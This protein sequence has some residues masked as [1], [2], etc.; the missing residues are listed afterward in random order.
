LRCIRTVELYCNAS[1]QRVNHEKSSIYFGKEVAG[2]TR[3]E[4]KVILNMENESLS[5]R[6]LGLP[7]DVGRSKN[8]TFAYLKDRVWKRL[9]GWMERL[10]S[11]GGKEI[12]RKSVIQV[13]PTYSM[14]LFKFPRGLCQHITSLIRQ[15]WW[16]SKKG[17]RKTTW[18]SWESMTMPKYRGGLGGLGFRDIE[19]FNLALLAR[20]V[21]RIIMDPNSLSAEILKAVY[22]PNYDILEASVGSNP[23]HIWCSLCEGRDILKQGLIRRI[24][25]GESTHICNTNWLP[26]DYSMRPLCPIYPDPPQ[27]V[28]ELICLTRTWNLEVLRKYFV[29]MDV[30]VIRHIH[31]SYMPQPDFWA[32]IYEK[33]VSFLYDRPT[34]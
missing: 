26:R 9:Q 20:Q 22:F 17:E 4:I 32:W 16:G 27:M 1:G 24:G 23:S 19:I 8:G 11:A 25:V 5:E 2:N 28:K 30:E 7:S 6:Y 34:K 15:F 13:I 21:W 3:G 31:F 18:V 33:Q 14:A 12:L 29:P 10:L